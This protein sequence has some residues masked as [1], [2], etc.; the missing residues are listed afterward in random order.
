MV[1]PAQIP[2]TQGSHTGWNLDTGDFVVRE[3]LFDG[4]VTLPAHR[5]EYACFSI[6]A[7]GSMEKSFHSRRYELEAPSLITIPHGELHSDWFGRRVTRIVVVEVDPGAQ[8]R[9]SVMES[10]GDL[11]DRVVEQRNKQIESFAHRF[12]RELRAPDELSGLAVSGLV[13]ELISTLARSELSMRGSGA[14]RPAWVRRV[15]DYLHD[16][17]TQ[18]TRI[19]AIAAEV[20]LHPAYLSRAFRE[21]VGVPLCAYARG[22]RLDRVAAELISTDERIL[23]I[24]L[25]AG[26]T[27]QSHLTRLFRRRFGVTPAQYRN[28]RR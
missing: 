4:G 11:T 1:A 17:D 24:A 16:N 8:R 12:S 9:H 10:G 21:H 26:F 25:D 28:K 19:D 13:F 7:S 6:L 15:I 20:E 14:P 5:H 23:D 27:D 2:V 18:A 3:L 22:I